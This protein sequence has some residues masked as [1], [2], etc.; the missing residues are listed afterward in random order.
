MRRKIFGVLAIIIG[1]PML[2][3]AVYQ[4]DEYFR[5]EKYGVQASIDASSVF[6]PHRKLRGGTEFFEESGIKS[7][8]AAIRRTHLSTVILKYFVLKR[9][10]CI[11][12]CVA[13]EASCSSLLT[14]PYD[15]PAHL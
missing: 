12:F 6:I 7:S 4:T 10:V 13:A 3:I 11:G 2:G 14:R 1:L 5:I 9:R 8:I 15:L